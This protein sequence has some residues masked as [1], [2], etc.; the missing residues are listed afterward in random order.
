MWLQRTENIGGFQHNHDKKYHVW[1]Y[2]IQ[3]AVDSILSLREFR[4]FL[5]ENHHQ[6]KKKNPLLST[7]LLP[8]PTC[9]TERATSHTHQ[10]IKNSCVSQATRIINWVSPPEFN[11]LEGKRKHDRLRDKAMAHT[12]TLSDT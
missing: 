5:G 7:S 2:N 8:I 10:L 1:N 6:S 9:G 3:E 12:E 4:E 11:L